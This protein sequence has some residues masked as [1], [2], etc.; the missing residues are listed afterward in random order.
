[1]QGTSSDPGIIPLAVSD[2]FGAIVDTPGREF[3]IRVSYLE[4]YNE[5]IKDLLNP[6]RDNL[7]IH[8][9]PDREIFVG[10]LTEE[11][12]LSPEDVSQLLI[13][14]ERNRHVGVTNMNERSSRSHTIFRMVRDFLSLSNYFT[15][16]RLSRAVKDLI[17][18]VKTRAR[19]MLFESPC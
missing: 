2:I 11:I 18:V 13:R 4:I 6:E 9:T 5:I 7:K 17:M 1:M 10:N 15:I 8:E 19:S 3:L 12:V 16:F 14:G